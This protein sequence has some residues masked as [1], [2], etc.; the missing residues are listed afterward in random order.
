MR[1]NDSEGEELEPDHIPVPHESHPTPTPS[2][3]PNRC[4]QIAGSPS[5]APLQTICP[6]ES[7]CSPPGPPAPYRRRLEFPAEVTAGL[8]SP[9]S[10]RQG[11]QF[12]S[13][14]LSTHLCC[15]RIS[16][17]CPLAHFCCFGPSPSCSQHQQDSTLDLRPEVLIR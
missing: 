2:S 8:F 17:F 5:Q 3:P 14:G 6:P 10:R 9:S 11:F 4:R 12:I 13:A 1:L 7:G 16:W 15:A